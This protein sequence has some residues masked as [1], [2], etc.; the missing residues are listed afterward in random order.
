MYLL[1]SMW[2]IKPD[3]F[4]LKPPKQ[5]Y[6]LSLRLLDCL[7]VIKTILYQCPPQAGPWACKISESCVR[8]SSTKMKVAS[9][10]LDPT[11]QS[12]FP[13][14]TGD[15]NIINMYSMFGTNKLD[16]LATDVC[17]WGWLQA[18]GPDPQEPPQPALQKMGLFASG[19]VA[20]NCCKWGETKEPQPRWT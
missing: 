12:L 15:I 20:S 1:C 16:L 10:Q 3:C 6:T 19:P 8:F 5:P 7:F 18:H 2:R 11:S 9:I 17:S 14:R 4:S 13:F